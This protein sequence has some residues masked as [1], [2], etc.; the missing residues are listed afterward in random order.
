MTHEVT[1]GML[2]VAGQHH[3]PI[4]TLELPWKDNKPRIS[5]VPDGDYKVI[6]H[7]SPKFG[8]CWW[9]QDVPGRSEILIHQANVASELLGCIAL[10]LSSGQLKGKPAVLSSRNAMAYLRDVIGNKAFDLTIR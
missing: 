3:A 4:Y 2:Q 1:L 8:K 6:S 7:V 9:L 10:G 5:C